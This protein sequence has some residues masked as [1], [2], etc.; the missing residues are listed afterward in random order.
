MRNTYRG[1]RASP[2][3]LVQRARRRKTGD[4]LVKGQ[5]H[6][7]GKS[8]IWGATPGCAKTLVFGTHPACQKMAWPVRHLAFSRVEIM[9]TRFLA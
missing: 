8:C 2:C 6:A 4:L 1:G 5:L 3:L 7:G 9:K